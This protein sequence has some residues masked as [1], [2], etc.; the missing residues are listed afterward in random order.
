MAYTYAQQL[1]FVQAAIRA[2][3]ADKV[4]SYSLDG[5]SYTYR[6]LDMLYKR[7]ERLLRM[8]E[9]NGKIVTRAIER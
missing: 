3:E 2:L 6:D 9:N 1:E 7:E 5:V 4:A 8:T